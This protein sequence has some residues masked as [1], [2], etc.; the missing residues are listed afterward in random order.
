MSRILLIALVAL[1][2]LLVTDQVRK[3]VPDEAAPVQAVR[4]EASRDSAA[5]APSAGARFVV[6]TD[7]GPSAVDLIARTEGRRLLRRSAGITYVDSLFFETDSVVRRWRDPQDVGLMIALVE[8]GDPAKDSQL[9]AIV[10]RALH[11]WQ[12]VAPGLRLVVVADTAAA[13]IVIQTV[14]SL[15]GERAGQTD[16]RWTRDGAIQGARVFI[17]L[18]T[19]DG[20]TVPNEGL[21]AVA[22]HEMGHALGLPHSGEP[23]DVMF[24]T[25]RTGYPTERDARSIRLLY[26]LPL[27]SVKEQE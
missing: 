25:T 13:G 14:D 19:G 17:A 10:S 15:E 16:L 4:L 6:V 21:F 22:S 9:A 1:V 3:L 12:E 18:R 8:S 2:A 27:G 26:E 7:S 23:L 5:P 24:G 11:A 20:S